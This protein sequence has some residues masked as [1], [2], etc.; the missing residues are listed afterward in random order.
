MFIGIGRLTRDPVFKMTSS[1]L[2]VCKFSIAIDRIGKLVDGKRQTDFFDCT[3]WRQKAEFVNNFL[4]KGRL[5][6]V[7]GR[8]EINTASGEDG[9]KRKFINITVDTIESL[10]TKAQV[11]ALGS[12]NQQKT[13][14]PQ[15]YQEFDS[16][17]NKQQPTQPQPPQQ[18]Q[19][20]ESAMDDFDMVD[21]F[22]DQN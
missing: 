5:V 3:A 1:G 18:H 15:P 20:P 19:H 9:I 11:E 21:P 12:N 8:V 6:A 14:P 22:A 7:T 10:E 17:Y 13:N 16:G 2:P 4:S